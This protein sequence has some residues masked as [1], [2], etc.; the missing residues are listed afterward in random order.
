M[1]DILGRP[2]TAAVAEQETQGNVQRVGRTAT[3]MN[4]VTSMAE[5]RQVFRV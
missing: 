1:I 4:I 2:L 5:V 3:G